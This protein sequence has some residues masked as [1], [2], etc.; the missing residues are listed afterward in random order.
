MRAHLRLFAAAFRANLAAAMEYRVNFLVQV[1][2]MVL[3][4]A[5]FIVFWKVLL[6]RTGALGGYG[7]RD[8]M[9][10]WALTAVA[11]GLAHVVFGNV[12]S[13]AD[14]IKGGE[15]D[16]YLLQPKD[17]LFSALTA[18]TIVAGWGDIAYGIGLFAWLGPSPAGWAAF[19]LFSL[20][21]A[22]TLSG[23]FVIGESLSFWAGGGEGL[24]GTIAELLLSFSLYPEKIFPEGMRW[25]FYSLIPSGF[26]VFVPLAWWRRPDALS[27]LLGA[28]AAVVYGLGAWLLFRAGLRH[29]E[30]GNRMGARS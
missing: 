15:L 12:R 5:A 26:V 9:F 19:A 4:N 8:I 23:V 2:G 16:V 24:G 17:V 27:L 25:I 20:C 18:R 10:L 6:D 7:F 3:N 28:G 13:L 21:A 11:F 30:S 1:G 14:L 29:Y 22:V